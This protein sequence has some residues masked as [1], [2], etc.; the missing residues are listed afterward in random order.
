VQATV[1]LRGGRASLVSWVSR[2]TLHSNTLCGVKVPRISPESYKQVI[3]LPWLRHYR[4][5]CQVWLKASVGDGKFKS[6]HERE[7]GR[8]II[9]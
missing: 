7:I 6:L 9:K 4:P 3:D 2:Q 5:I 1:I 8:C